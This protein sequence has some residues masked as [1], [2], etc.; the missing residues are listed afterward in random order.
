[1]NEKETIVIFSAYIL[2]HLGGIERYTANLAKELVKNYNI[3][4]VS[5]NYENIDNTFYEKEGI[6]YIHLP[7]LKLFVNRYPLMKKNKEFKNLMKKLDNYSIKAIIVN[8]RFHLTSMVGAKYGRKNNI[9]VFL[10]EHGSGHLTVDNKVLDFFGAIYEHILTSVLKRYVDKYYG[11]SIEACTWQKHF[12][13]TSSGV[14]Y[15]SINDFSDSVIKKSSK[16]INILYT[17]RVL[18]QKGIIELINSFNKLSKKYKNINLTIAGDGNLLKELKKKYTNVNF[19][20]KVDFEV[21]KELYRRCDI[22]VYA[23]IW[24]EGLPTSILE[25]G[26]MKCAIVCSNKG[27]IKEIITNGYNGLMINN[28]E[29]LYSAIEKLINDKKLRLLLGNNIEKTIRDN[30]LWSNTAK[31]IIND[32]NS[33]RSKI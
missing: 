11:V 20:G 10:I 27:G 16:T 12:N 19:L 31:T 2:P 13:I 30:F 6:T 24:P 17:G 26:L 15:N 7:A 9:P 21:L 8:T 3:V 1:M 32:I 25:S 33:Y 28:E 5:T 14:W 23:P 29:E 22:Y 18:K 4:I